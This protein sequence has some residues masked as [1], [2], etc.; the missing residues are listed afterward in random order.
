MKYKIIHLYMG[1]VML[2]NLIIIILI[3]EVF[4]LIILM[5]IRGVFNL[6][7]IIMLMRG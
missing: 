1:V 6:I 7:I 5:L 4:N 2:Y 3:W